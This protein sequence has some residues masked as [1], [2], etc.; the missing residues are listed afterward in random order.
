[1]SVTQF[2]LAE[3]FANITGLETIERFGTI[4]VKDSGSWVPVNAQTVQQA[5]QQSG[6]KFLGNSVSG[7]NVV[8]SIGQ[9]QVA[10]SVWGIT[11]SYTGRCFATPTQ[12]SPGI[13][14]ALSNTGRAQVGS[15]AL[16][17][18]TRMEIVQSTGGQAL[19]VQAKG[20]L[21]KVPM[22]AVMRACAAAQGVMLGID[23][24]ESNPELATKIS[25]I[26]LN[27]NIDPANIA[28]IVENTTVWA[29][30]RDGAVFIT[31]DIIDAVR[32]VFLDE[33]VYDT[34]YSGGYY[35][36][37]AGQ[38]DVFM[39][40]IVGG[41]TRTSKLVCE[42]LV[43]TRS[44]PNQKIYLCVQKPTLVFDDYGY[45]GGR[46][47][48]K[49]RVAMYSTASFSVTGMRGTTVNRNGEAPDPTLTSWSKSSYYPGAGSIH[50]ISGVS[51]TV[52]Q[53]NVGEDMSLSIQTV[54]VDEHL[55]DGI[56]TLVAPYPEVNDGNYSAKVNEQ[57]L[58]YVV[59]GDRTNELEPPTAISVPGTK[60]ID[61]ATYPTEGS[62]TDVDYPDWWSNKVETISSGDEEGDI[63]T[64]PWLPVN[65]FQPES[66]EPSDYS[67]ASS[68]DGTVT[69]DDEMVDIIDG[70]D[71]SI[72]SDP[73]ASEQTDPQEQ[74][75]PN[76]NPQPSPSTPTI[77]PVTPTVDTSDGES[78]DPTSPILT[79]AITSGL[80]H[81]Y[82]PTLTEVQAVGRKL[83]TL[84]FVENLKKIF[85]DPMDG[86]VGFLIIYA[87]PKTG[88]RKNI[89]L[90]IY[91]TEVQSKIVTNQYVTIDCGTIA[92][93]EYF[94]DARD[95]SP[96]TNV[97]LYLPFIGV[98]ELYA[99]DVINS[100]VN[101]QYHV[102]VLTG[103][104][105]A[106]VKVSKGNASAVV[107]QYPGNCG[108][109]IPLTSMNYSSIIT[110]LFSVGISA[111]GGAALGTAKAVGRRLAGAAYGAARAAAI[112]ASSSTIDV[113]QSGS[114]GSNAGA[115]GIRNPY[116]IIRRPVT[117]DA[118]AYN[119]QYGYPANKWVLLENMK[120]FTRVKSIHLD[121]LVC[122][123]E[124]KEMID[125][126]LKEGVVF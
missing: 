87:T 50:S 31:Q 40:C 89:V 38:L 16:Q 59:D 13:Q 83:W 7:G 98:V 92:V 68:Q 116:F 24:V 82:N 33:G 15:T 20:I 9:P 86:I 121:S 2:S 18:V 80:A 58:A 5:V 53:T 4:M 36:G 29:N 48:L 63:V 78:P 99:D 6:F 62:S 117:S 97:S 11:E 8:S 61:G 21:T 69:S 56:F 70:I 110:S 124:E 103:T 112:N 12:L 118:Y 57:I 108:V 107:Y 54:I 91:D 22:K 64:T 100:H 34:G 67:Q 120:G 105:L 122:T 123:D 44:S 93:D 65:I 41:R 95:Y 79:T 81:I 26:I 88:E 74:V 76:P 35:Y 10:K 115:M 73:D 71:E 30:V 101:I 94:N 32:T 114:I 126:A 52:D 85:V 119:I 49:S 14:S 96:Y 60:L 125:S 77:T 1:M 55:F 90:G 3:A 43:I 75:Y 104:C 25:N 109:Q 113:Q 102:D 45:P 28:S 111:V 37:V 27:T 72:E 84:D 17:P 66:D 47:D 19:E 51:D 46:T 39:T 23:F 42:N 106:T